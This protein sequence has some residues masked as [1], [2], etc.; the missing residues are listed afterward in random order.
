[1]LGKLNQKLTWM[2]GITIAAIGG[3][4]L[5]WKRQPK[6]N[7]ETDLSEF[8]EEFKEAARKGRT[9]VG[10][11]QPDQ[12]WLYSLYKQATV[13]D[14]NIPEPMRLHLQDHAKWTAWSKCKGVKK[15]DAEKLYIKQIQQY[16]ESGV[17]CDTGSAQN[18]QFGMKVSTMKN[19]E[20]D[21]NEAFIEKINK[22]GQTIEQEFQLNEKEQQIFQEIL[23]SLE[24]TDKLGELLQTHND[25]KY[26]QSENQQKIKLIHAVVDIENVEA[27]KLLIP[28]YKQHNLMNV[29]ES[30]SGMTALHYACL[31]GNQEILELLLKNGAD[32]KIKDFSGMDS[33][34]TI[35]AENKQWLE[36]L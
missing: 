32:P 29:Q 16:L 11:S 6:L 34:E 24:N 13:G 23:D 27:L 9:L 36:Q 10:L 14:C 19:A 12:L 17:E 8:S 31:S 3:S 5:F 1:M 2:V 15:G 33:Y 22:T 7:Q 26:L 20:H 25:V 21:T 18:S 4:L 35:D 30:V 28:Y